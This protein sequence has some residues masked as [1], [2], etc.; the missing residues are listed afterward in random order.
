M[1]G[2]SCWFMSPLA[3]LQGRKARKKGQGCPKPN[4]MTVFTK[5]NDPGIRKFVS[6]AIELVNSI[7][8]RKPDFVLDDLQPDD[9]NSF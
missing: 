2:I 3:S 5:L 9:F 6:R 7:T 1:K 4:P 8:T